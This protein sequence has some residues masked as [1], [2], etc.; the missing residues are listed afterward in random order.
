M[1]KYTIL[2]L[3]ISLF[4]SCTEK[5][6]IN[7]D[8]VLITQGGVFI[9]NEGN[10]SAANSS[11]SYY[12]IN[13]SK[14]K[15][16]LFYEVNNVPLGDVAQSMTIVNDM[17][18]VV[19][20]NSGLIYGLDRETLEFKG[21][22]VSLISPREMI[23]INNQKAYVSDLYSTEIAVVNPAT[24]SITSKIEIGKSSDCMVKHDD[25]IMVANWS[26][27]NQDGINNTI[28]IINS[29]TDALADS[30]VVGIEPN[31]M[32]ID[33]DNLLWVLCSGGFMN[34]EIPTL[35]KINPVT[36]D[37]VKQFTFSNILHSPDNLCINGTGDSL[38]FLNNGV[39]KMSIYDLQLP[40]NV[41]INENNRNYYSLG[42]HPI[43]NEIYVSDALDYNQNGLVY[44]Y[45]SEGKLVS[46][47]E[48]G[49]IPGCFAFN[50]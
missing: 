1:I 43:E 45:S 50:N 8:E 49:I 2:F 35:W 27:F 10:F 41:T 37:I 36:L 15:N 24:Y 19:I 4:F 44:R 22:I 26:S 30:I 25:K 39:Y 40:D 21:K 47:F 3:S 6:D 11:F 16:N 20:N 28:M 31:S 48:V 29:Q 13:N 12:N 33:K 32:V 17:V 38:Y 9:V 34:D 42:I 18:Y 46:S 7:Q 14:I 23:I 5:E